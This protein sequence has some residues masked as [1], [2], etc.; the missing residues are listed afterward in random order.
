MS[1]TEIVVEDVLAELLDGDD[2]AALTE[3]ETD[4]SLMPTAVGSII[5]TFMIHC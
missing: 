1:A 4:P 2:V 3:L 5:Y